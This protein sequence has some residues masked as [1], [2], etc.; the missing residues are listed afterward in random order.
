MTTIW[1]QPPANGS[2]PIE[3]EYLREKIVPLMTQGYRQVAPPVASP[4]A[5]PLTPP[6]PSSNAEVEAAPGTEIPTPGKQ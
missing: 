3:V 4:V 6:A 1:L 5:S 2:A